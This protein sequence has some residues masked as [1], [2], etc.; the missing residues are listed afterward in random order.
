[1]FTAVNQAGCVEES[2]SI[3]FLQSKGEMQR[4]AQDVADAKAVP[5]DEHLAATE[6]GIKVRTA[7]PQGDHDLPASAAEMCMQGFS[8]RPGRVAPPQLHTLELVEEG[9]PPSESL[10]PLETLPTLLTDISERSFLTKAD[11]LALSQSTENSD[12]TPKSHAEL[13]S[14]SSGHTLE[15]KRV[16]ISFDAPEALEYDSDS[17]SDSLPPCRTWPEVYDSQVRLEDLG[18]SHSLGAVCELDALP[19]LHPLPHQPQL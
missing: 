17:S 1:V 15:S 6:R 5:K 18:H 10:P 7:Q 19:P 2:G 13:L 9:L 16:T 3:Q 8:N 11:T 14:V 12:L 4:Q